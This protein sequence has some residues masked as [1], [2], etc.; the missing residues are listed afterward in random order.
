MS[1][2]TFCLLAVL[3][4]LAPLPTC[5]AQTVRQR[6][7]TDMVVADDPARTQTW[8][9]H[10]ETTVLAQAGLQVAGLA[11]LAW[12]GNQTLE[13][14]EAYTR[15][16]DGRRVPVQEA[17]IVTQEGAIGPMA[18]LI[19]L[20]L[21]QI[22]FRDVEIGDTVVYTARYT[23]RD[24]YVPGQFSHRVLVNPTGI[25]VEVD[26]TLTAPAGLALR[27]DE[28]GSRYTEERRDGTI[29]RR[30]SG[31]F[32]LAPVSE[33]PVADL[34][35][36]LPRFDVSTYGSYE[37][38]GRAYGAAAVP[39]AVP[40]PAVRA[41]ADQIT[42]GLG[43]P[44]DQAAAILAWIG[45]NVRYVAVYLGAGRIVPNDAETVLARRYGD[46]KDK[47]TLM[48]ALLAAKGIAAEEV[49]IQAGFSYAL[50]DTPVLQAFNHLI[51]HVPSLD[52]YA[53]PTAPFASLGA[54]P[55]TLMGKPVVAVLDGRTA[56]LDRVPVGRM[57]D[58]RAHVARRTVIGSDGQVVSDVTL[59]ATGEFAQELR[60]F[61][62][63]AQ[64]RG[65]QAVIDVLARARNLAGRA[66][67]AEWPDPYTANGPARLSTHLEA[68]QPVRLAERGWRPAQPLS[69]IVPTATAVVE[70]G[71]RGRRR[72]PAP[73]RPGRV[74]EED[75]IVLP[76]DLRLASPLPAPI[77]VAVGAIRYERRWTEAG[78]TLQVRTVIASAVPDRRCAP[79]QVNA[80]LA[81]ADDLRETIDPLLRFA[82]VGDP[83]QR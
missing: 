34:D 39:R 66:S 68:A 24:H 23:E 63:T 58:N 52:A 11:R 72:L 21:R 80:L 36:T 50:P 28:S 27:H 43:D 46:C 56:R 69:P 65:R 25:P 8:T 19:D 10:R 61:E 16:P 5:W 12:L 7:V 82:K 14:L 13:I 78:G 30:W 53:D 22:A 41:L 79:D 6:V 67:A 51:V 42:A 29:V 20:K 31:T 37:E 45:R 59:E 17:E 54:P 1:R 40:G 15:K 74:E 35:L 18:S 26:F 9:E 55:G 81:A 32:D 71:S 4:W 83:P 77:A 62:A 49:L 73:C 3:A 48:V 60:R 64:A 47:A 57:E 2:T 38:I 44:R 33:K 75:T 70:L 76:P